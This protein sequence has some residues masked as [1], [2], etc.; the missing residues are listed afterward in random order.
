MAN[1]VRRFSKALWL[2]AANEQKAQKILSQRE[3]DDACNNWVNE[4]DGKTEEELAARGI[5]L[6]ENWFVA[7]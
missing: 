7:D 1:K 2:Q 6:N 5:Q 3:I 4:I